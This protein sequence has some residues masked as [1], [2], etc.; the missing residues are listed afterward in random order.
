MNC[1]A[2]EQRDGIV[3]VDCGIQFPFDDL[4]VDVLHPDFTWLVERADRVAGVFLT[5]GHE[6]HIGGLPYFLSRVRAPV[7]GPPHALELAKERLEEHGFDVD[8][9]ELHRTGPGTS[10]AVGPFEV[11][12]VRVS[13]SIVEA[14]ALRVQTS[15]GV[16]LHTGDFNLDPD[17][18]DGEP[19]DADRLRGIGDEGVRV[20]LSDS[21]NVDVESRAGSERAVG[22]ALRE[23]VSGA[24][25][26]VVVAMF[27]SNIQRLILLGELA[28]A[29]G[30]KLCLFGRSLN[31]QLRVAERI[32]RLRWPPGLVVSA[33]EAAA[34]P[35]NELLVLAGGTQAE[36][37]SAMRR[38]ASGTHPQLKLAEGDSVI[39]SSRIIPGNDRAV[40]DMLSDLLRE[41]V[42][43]LTRVT[44]PGVH[45]SGHAGRSEQRQMIEWTRPR[46]FV[47]V[48][49][50]LHHLT[51][52]A[53]LA[54]EC[55]VADVRVVEN[56][57]PLV[58]SP[59]VVT[60][61]QRVR[62]GK[63]R[64]AWGGVVM[65]EAVWQR[66]AELGRGGLV[67]ASIAV[68]SS[69]RPLGEA[70]VTTLG[71]PALDDDA[72]ARRRLARSVT[73]ELGRAGKRRSGDAVEDVVRALRREVWTIGR[74][75]PMVEV[76]LV[77]PERAPE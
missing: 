39:L 56:G 6:D 42:R 17:P 24:P 49:G 45:T 26:R 40:Y 77:E 58:V 60:V 33:E 11:E 51:R 20:L 18:P 62:S 14:S 19:T 59:D 74:S 29:N 10:Y 12:P 27:A 50:T 75:R 72:D 63:V 67:L 35:R 70:V 21:T 23:L 47:P 65:D 54:R 64:V 61:E 52:H 43:V 36:H 9:L 16:L 41:G 3:V 31:T 68:D 5:H 48:H 32:G 44:H 55:G 25:Q 2:L 15:A 34:L 28:R 8:A 76:H 38:L 1:F 13:H 7:W 37:H 30:R 22:S 53:E 66:R 57:Q 73:R 4:G 71:V 69:G 46:S